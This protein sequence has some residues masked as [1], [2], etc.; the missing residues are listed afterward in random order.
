MAIYTKMGDGGKTS[1][2]DKS[3]GKR[4]RV[5]KDS[6]KIEVIGVIDELNSFLGVTIS[7]SNISEISFYLKEAQRSLLTISSIIAGKKLR[8]NLSETKKLE[9]II[10]KFEKNLPALSNFILPG[11]TV[12]ASHLQFVRSLARKA[13]RRIASLSQKEKVNSSILVYFN[14]LSDLLFILARFANFEAKVSEE[15]WLESKRK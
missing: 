10:N 9:K 14:R 11:G 2:Y 13:E 7:F 6:L 5:S 1:L 15:V 12:L 3:G 8:F 4:K